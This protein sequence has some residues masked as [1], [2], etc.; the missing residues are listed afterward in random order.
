[1]VC[2]NDRH[3]YC[4]K[5]PCFKYNPALISWFINVSHYFWPS[6]SKG[7][8]APVPIMDRPLRNWFMLSWSWDTGSKPSV[9]LEN[10]PPFNG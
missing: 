9:E 5:T 2:V 7:S 1:M 8:V 10:I 6:E 4:E 3:G